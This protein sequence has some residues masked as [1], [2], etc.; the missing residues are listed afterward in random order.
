MTDAQPVSL[1]MSVLN[2]ERHLG[3]A[4]QAALGQDYAA[5]LELVIALGPSRDAT[6]EIAEKLAADDPRIQ[7][8]RNP[9]G[10]TPAGLNLA[11]AAAK[12]PIVARVDGHALL[13]PGYLRTAV[14][15]LERSG[16]D[17]VGGMMWAEGVSTYEQAVAR[18]MT[19]PLGN[20]PAAFHSGGAEGPT[21]T[22]YLGVFRR[23]TLLR[24]GGYDESFVR[25]QDWELNYRIRQDGGV[26][27]FTPDL[28][29]TYRP[30]ATTRALAKQY[31]NYGRWRGTLIRRYP[32]SAN[33][34]YLAPPLALISIVA[35]AV[36][37]GTGRRWGLLPAAGYAAAIL[38]GSV[39]TGRSLPPGALVRL[40]GVYATMHGSWA[41]GFLSGR[42][43]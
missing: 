22:V 15:V 20:G 30:R 29:V 34:R 36:V 38:A 40:P 7:L 3:T 42:R 8:V 16:A 1:V 37:A 33:V 43:R 18:A 28:R 17:N 9:T 19:S 13:P 41:V 31:F 11:V 6:D 26:V 5:E 24:L 2:E 23:D 21:D 4:V 39:A 35:G 12:H 27:Y 14:D 25:A 32:E 10:L